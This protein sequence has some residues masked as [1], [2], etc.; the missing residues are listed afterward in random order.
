MFGGSSP[1]LSELYS[2]IWFDY[3]VLGSSQKQEEAAKRLIDGSNKHIC[4][5]SFEFL[6]STRYWKAQ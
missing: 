6:E 5:L 2:K 1:M 3:R 4:R